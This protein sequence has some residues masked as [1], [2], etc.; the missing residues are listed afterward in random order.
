MVGTT[1]S[2]PA[3]LAADLRTA[4]HR[5]DHNRPLRSTTSVLVDRSLM[6]FSWQE[7]KLV[8]CEYVTDVGL[9]WLSL[10]CH[11][12]THLDLQNCT[13]VA[14][15]GTRPFGAARA[16]KALTRVFD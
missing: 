1:M 9:H 6:R 14:N 16:F 11:A 3:T 4:S 15:P 13:K 7:L 2:R 12:L 5:Q 10:G 8:N